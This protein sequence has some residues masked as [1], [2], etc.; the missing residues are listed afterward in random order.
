MRDTLDLDIVTEKGSQFLNQYALIR[1]D[2]TKNEIKS[3]EADE[4]IDWMMSKQGQ[5]LIGEYGKEKY[6]MP[7]FTPNAIRTNAEK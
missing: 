2:P 3:E 5:E 7:L 4:F 6:G 1:L